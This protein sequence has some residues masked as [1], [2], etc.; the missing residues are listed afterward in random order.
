VFYRHLLFTPLDALNGPRHIDECFVLPFHH[1]ILMWCV[2]RGELVLNSLL[3]KV[4]FNLYVFELQAI[5]ASNLLD[6]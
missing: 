1:T 6:P 2:R 4:L 5:V 3:L